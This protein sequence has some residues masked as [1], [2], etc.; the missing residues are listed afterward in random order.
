M[1][2]FFTPEWGDI[3]AKRWRIHPSRQKPGWL[4]AAGVTDG[5]QNI[6][7]CSCFMLKIG[8]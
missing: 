6:N 3:A 5:A 8:L 1:A 4:C 7:N 2:P